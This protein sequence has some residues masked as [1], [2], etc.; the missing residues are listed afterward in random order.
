M[1]EGLYIVVII[2]LKS[3]EGFGSGKEHKLDFCTKF[4][5]NGLDAI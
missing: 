4:Y 2:L 1:N 5:E 3:D